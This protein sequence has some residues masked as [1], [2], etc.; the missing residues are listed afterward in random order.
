MYI[1]HEQKQRSS[2]IVILIYIISS[3]ILLLVVI[4]PR[5]LS[6][7]ELT[8]V[9]R[10]VLIIVLLI[11]IFF[12][13]SFYELKFKIT[14]EGLEFG[15]GLLKN[16][17]SKNS[18]KSISIYSSKGNFFG[19][20]IRFNKSKVM[21]F[22]AQ[23]GEGLEITHKDQRKFFITMNNPQEALDIIKENNYV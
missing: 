3:I 14:N 1:I 17:I 6:L 21:G 18:I 19:Y 13:E 23:H 8:K 5:F 11:D 10:I 15:Y 12:L 16:K 7:P 4:N 9:S 20:G 22:I 2:I